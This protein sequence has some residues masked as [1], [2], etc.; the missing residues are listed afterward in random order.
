MTE[1]HTPTSFYRTSPQAFHTRCNYLWHRRLESPGQRGILSVSGAALVTYIVRT[2]LPFGKEQV[3]ETTVLKVPIVMTGSV[4][5]DIDALAEVIKVFRP[6]GFQVTF[7]DDTSLKYLCV[8]VMWWSP[9]TA[10]LDV[11]DVDPTGTETQCFISDGSEFS[12]VVREFGEGVAVYCY[13]EG[14]WL[15]SDRPLT[16]EHARILMEVRK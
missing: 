7:E 1:M 6:D 15:I 5:Q 16:P 3:T 4:H 13:G 2:L 12:R 9:N 8:V 14:P 11:G 10:R